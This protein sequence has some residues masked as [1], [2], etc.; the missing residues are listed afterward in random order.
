LNDAIVVPWLSRSVEERRGDFKRTIPW[1][2]ATARPNFWASPHGV[3]LKLT[4]LGV[5]VELFGVQEAWL[6]LMLGWVSSQLTRSCGNLRLASLDVRNDRHRTVP[7][8]VE[9][10]R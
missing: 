5:E 6:D 7:D 8:C 4:S 2:V 9:E 3:S 10:L 1:S